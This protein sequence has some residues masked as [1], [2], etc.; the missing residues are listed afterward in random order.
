M[1]AAMSTQP[2]NAHRTTAYNIQNIEEDV[3][4]LNNDITLNFSGL[5]FPLKIKDIKT[6]ESCNNTISI[7][8]FGCDNEAKEII[9]P[10]YLTKE[11]RIQHINLMLLEDT[12]NFHYIFIKNISG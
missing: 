7:N 11:E 9:G 10:F 6:F 2:A 8:V 12:N 5:R 1:I 4:T 3:I